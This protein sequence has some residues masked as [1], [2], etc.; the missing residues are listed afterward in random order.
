MVGKCAA[1]SGWVWESVLR[2]AAR[3]LV[4]AIAVGTG[5][6][7][8]FA[9]EGVIRLAVPPKN[10]Q[11]GGDSSDSAIAAMEGRKAFDFGAFQARLEGLWFQRRALLADG[12]DSDAAHQADLIR[13]FCAEEG[14]HRMADLAAALVAESRR[15]LDEGNYEKALGSLELAEALD[16]GRS[17][18]H[19][20]KAAVLRKSGEGYLS[21][22]NEMLA[23][24]RATLSE[25]RRNLVIFDEAPVILV[26]GVL[27]CIALFSL[28]M[29]VSHHV[30]LRHE[31]EEALARRDA[32]KWGPLAGWLVL[33]LP[34][35]TWIAAG[36]AALYWIVA[37]FRYMRRAERVA[38]VLLLMAV[39][40]AVPAYRLAV[41]FYGITA[42]PVVDDTVAA[43]SGSYEPERTVRMRE[44][45]ESHP[46]EPLYRFLLAGLYK[47]GRYFEEAYLQYKQ[48]LSLEP[49]A[50]KGLI[51]LGN[52]FFVTGQYAEATIQYRK[53]L[54]VRPDSILALYNLHLAQSES[55]NFKEAEATLNRA[56]AIDSRRIADLLAR[57]KKAGERPSVID[58]TVGSGT[59][60][61]SFLNG[62]KLAGWLASDDRGTSG[63]EIAAEF[64]NPLSI[65]GLLALVGC[66]V[67]AIAGRRSQPAAR[68]IRCGRPFCPLCKSGREGKDYCSQC[69]HL[70]VLGD[71]LAPE[72]KTH[73]MYE[74][75]RYESRRRLIP[76]LASLILPGSGHVLAGK[77]LVG[78]TLLVLW[79]GALLAA[80]PSIAAPLL[81]FAGLDLR[82]DLLRPAGVPAGSTLDCYLLVAVPIA[83]AA[84]LWAN[85]RR[86]GPRE[87]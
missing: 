29:V 36:W 5:L 30:P 69:L 37:T 68:C 72:T 53:A 74:V 82:L 50:D 56:Q 22:G 41:A 14:I 24:A 66:G 4:I 7:L 38:A 73:K 64:L 54:E 63:S 35:L 61:R 49:S 87:A 15:Y 47:N 52:I 83:V 40:A 6:P 34:L 86:P 57:N 84:W 78:C 79:A 62:G 71:G 10:D 39:I 80:W 8:V 17:Q 18:V 2:V 55:F 75:H 46:S 28:L 27:A 16:P 42:D 77:P 67:I 20:A 76:R 60:L 45:V 31:V 59:V 65:A 12:R 85:V 26:L 70:F 33:L 19:R 44:L 25:A 21:A 9:D 3:L 32:E 13:A 1:A 81:R 43:A 23:A 48:L 58:A 11:P 51:N